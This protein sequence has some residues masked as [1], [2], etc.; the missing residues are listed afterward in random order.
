MSW[1]DGAQG[2]KEICRLAEAYQ[3]F[4]LAADFTDSPVHKQAFQERAKYYAIEF[5][6]LLSVRRLRR[7]LHRGYE[8][9]LLGRDLEERYLLYEEKGEIWD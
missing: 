7:S 2:R 3:E 1:S 5:V 6:R 8:A 9:D 4:K